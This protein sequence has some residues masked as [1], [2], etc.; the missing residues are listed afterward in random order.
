M[1]RRSGGLW[2]GHNLHNAMPHINNHELL[3]SVVAAGVQTTATD[4]IRGFSPYTSA[5]FVLTLTNAEAD[6]DDTLD[7]YIQRLLP[8]ETN[9]DDM[10]HFT[11]ILGNGANDQV[12][13]ADVYAGAGGGDERVAADAALAV[14]TVSDIS[15]GDAIRV[16]Y[17]IVDPSGTDATFT[18]S[19]SVNMLV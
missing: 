18:F 19:V 14:G 8:D 11:Q 12:F 17:V 1:V 16:K 10:V 3:A 2:V 15:W 5:T 4:P 7:V 6:A 9:W 13:V